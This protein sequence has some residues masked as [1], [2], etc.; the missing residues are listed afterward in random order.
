[1]LINP[2][3]WRLVYFS[4]AD[5]FLCQKMVRKTYTHVCKT[6][7]HDSFNPTNPVS[8]WSK[9]HGG[10]Y[11]SSVHIIFL[12]DFQLMQQ[13]TGLQRPADAQAV[14]AGCNFSRRGLTLHTTGIVHFILFNL[15]T[16]PFDQVSFK[17]HYKKLL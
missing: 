9:I 12:A 10:L 15:I 13:L 16:I 5:I 6:Y 17:V 1:M 3:R 7:T 8:D 14:W 11:R 2:A 4:P